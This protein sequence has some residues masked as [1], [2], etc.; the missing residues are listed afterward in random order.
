M[1]LK[2]KLSILSLSIILAACGGS[3]D[4]DNNCG[5]S[6][7]CTSEPV[8]TAAIIEGKKLYRFEHGDGSSY[9]K[10]YTVFWCDT[11]MFSGGIIYTNI[12]SA[13][14]MIECS[15]D[16]VEAGNYSVDGNNIYAMFSG[17]SINSSESLS[18][19]FE[20]LNSNEPYLLLGK[21]GSD[22]ES[23]RL[24]E[25]KIE[26]E[27]L[28]KNQAFSVNGDLVTIETKDQVENA[29]YEPDDILDIDVFF[30]GMTCSEVNDKYEKFSLTGPALDNGIFINT[31]LVPVGSGGFSTYNSNV[32]VWEDS[33]DPYCALDYD[34]TL[35]DYNESDFSSGDKY[36]FV[37]RAKHGKEDVKVVAMVP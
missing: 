1:K 31:E 6:N 34:F 33:S 36:Y 4:E 16:L 35:A 12:R 30:E 2:S 23:N 15:A 9:G 22:E 37:A 29:Q 28:L 10:D 18:I 17:V 14:N 25:S 3:D 5:D 24:Y 27:A 13:E 7:S 21:E 20:V 8:E 19:E 32:S 11:W 26:V